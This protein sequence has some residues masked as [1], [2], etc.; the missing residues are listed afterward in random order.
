MGKPCLSSSTSRRPNSI[1]KHGHQ[2]AR[3]A[4]DLCHSVPF[5]FDKVNTEIEEAFLR[6]ASIFGCTHAEAARVLVVKEL[7][8]SCVWISKAYAE[9]WVHKNLVVFRVG[10]AHIIILSIFFALSLMAVYNHQGTCPFNTVA[11]GLIY[12]CD[13]I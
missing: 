5:C 4:E 3:C 9:A 8:W 12:S 6:H 1:W 11:W 10:Q 7:F 2:E 13:L